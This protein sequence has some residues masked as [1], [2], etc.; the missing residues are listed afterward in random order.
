MVALLT[1]VE[2]SSKSLSLAA[3]LVKDFDGRRSIEPRPDLRLEATLKAAQWRV[4]ANAVRTRDIMPY[5]TI[6]TIYYVDE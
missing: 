6:L 2:N 5:W 3:K 1:L 4:A